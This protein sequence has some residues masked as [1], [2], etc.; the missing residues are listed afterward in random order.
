M[1]GLGEAWEGLVAE[2]GRLMSETGSDRRRKRRVCTG[3]VFFSPWPITA[4]ADGPRS[5]PASRT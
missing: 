1:S 4:T 5:F 2:L 3:D